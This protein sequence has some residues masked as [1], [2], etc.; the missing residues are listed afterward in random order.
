MSLI[1]TPG[2]RGHWRADPSRVPHGHQTPADGQGQ[3]GGWWAAAGS[4]HVQ[5]TGR[6][7]G[8]NGVSW[9]RG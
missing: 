2:Q 7:A 3:P 4:A 5:V 8:E 1:P 6:Q 9:R